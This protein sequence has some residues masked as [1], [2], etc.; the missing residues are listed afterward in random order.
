MGKPKVL[1]VGTGFAGFHC[2]KALEKALPP[3]AADLVAVNPTDYMLYVPLL[4]EVAGG[5]LDPRRVAVPL[6][7]ELPRTRLVQAHAT[8]VDPDA[9]TCT[10]IDVEG[11]SQVI[12]W[13]R[14]V[15]TAGSVTRL[16]S[17]PGVA[18]HALGFKSVA[19]AVYLRDHVLRQIE[20]AEQDGDP[21]RTTFVVVG[22]GYTGT[23]LVAQGQQLALAAARG[24]KVPPIR[25]VLLDLAPRVLPGLD[26]RLSGPALKVLRQRGV[27]VRLETSVAEVTPTC[28]KLTDGTEIPTRTAVWCV[29]VRPDPLVESVDLPTVKGRLAVGA[30]LLVP[31]RSDVFAAGDMAAVPDVF[32]GGKPTPM[33]AQHAQRQGKLAAHNVA[34]SLGHGTPREYRHRDLGFVVD[35]AGAQAVAN[36]L[37]LP[38]TGWPAKLVARGYHLLAMPGNRV[39]VAA[40]WLTGLLT[41]RQV[42]RF[43]LVPAAGVRLA[44]ADRVDAGSARETARSAHD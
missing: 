31:G 39:R 11:R 25:W 42:V 8:S 34:A 23:E 12:T 44:D 37:H 35:L 2:L 24:R 16:M 13:D 40:D 15:L 3:D 26:E 41:R 6:R 36:P 1:V 19:E 9:R 20:L 21:A 28:A 4:P 29:G 22:A 17:V 33:T 7:P 5:T 10:A 18:E 30:D 27:D 14:I 32:N 43:D 38:L